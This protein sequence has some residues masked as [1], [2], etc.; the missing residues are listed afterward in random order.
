MRTDRV[1]GVSP[2]T[3]GSTAGPPGRPTA[4]GSRWV[5]SWRSATRTFARFNADGSGLVRL[6][7]DPARDYGAV[8][9]SGRLAF[10]TERF[11]PETIAVLDDEGTVRGV[12]EGTD[13]RVVARRHP[14]RVHQPR[15]CLRCR[16]DGRCCPESHQRRAGLLRAGVVAGWRR[17]GI[18]RDVDRRILRHVL[19]RRW[20]AQR[21]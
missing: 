20:R 11:G 16:G 6:T 1:S 7:T 2:I 4:R 8:F 3:S 19:L 13:S 21:R 14:D 17:G 10:V 12:S 5:V 9:T 18:W 15:R